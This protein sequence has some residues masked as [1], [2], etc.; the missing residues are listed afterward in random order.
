MLPSSIRYNSLIQ[1]AVASGRLRIEG[2]RATI[3]APSNY[4]ELTDDQWIALLQEASQIRQELERLLF[5][6]RG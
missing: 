5:T 4:T 2:N 3:V 1:S 6:V